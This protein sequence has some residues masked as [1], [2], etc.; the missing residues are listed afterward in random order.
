MFSLYGR[1]KFIFC[2]LRRLVGQIKGKLFA[3][4]PMDNDFPASLPPPYTDAQLQYQKHHLAQFLKFSSFCHFLE[5]GILRYVYCSYYYLQTISRSGNIRQLYV[6]VSF[7]RVCFWCAFSD[8]QVPWRRYSRAGKLD[9]VHRERSFYG[10]LSPR[11]FLNSRNKEK[12]HLSINTLWAMLRRF[13][14]QMKA[15][16][17]FSPF[18]RS[19]CQIFPI[20]N[21]IFK[22]FKNT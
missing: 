4:A 16:K 9:V 8:W 13:T 3:Y 21:R 10:T 17:F 20:G 15:L 1:S 2:S 7:P 22:N 11:D 19:K 18:N 12:I 5:D 14:A 6:F